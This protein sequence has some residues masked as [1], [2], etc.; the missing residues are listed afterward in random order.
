[1]SGRGRGRPPKYE[2][3]E[4]LAANIDVYFDY[5][6][7]KSKPP[8]MAGLAIFLG[9]EDRASTLDQAKRG[10][11]FS[12]A[13]NFART[14]IEA[15]REDLLLDKNTFT[16]GVIFSLKNNHGWKDKL[17]MEHDHKGGVTVSIDAK[18]SKL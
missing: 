12:R 10:E 6:E 9:F 17:D 11:D 5:C 3:A 16:P 7:N 4:Q 2:S 1:M 18:D 8:T 13:I 14:R 15:H